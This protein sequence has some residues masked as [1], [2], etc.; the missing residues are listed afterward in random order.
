MIN[1]ILALNCP[2]TP[3]H[4]RDI[5][6]AVVTGAAVD[7]DGRIHAGALTVH[8]RPVEHPITAEVLAEVLGM[9][10]NIQVGFAVNNKSDEPS[11]E[12]AKAAMTVAAA[13]LAVLADSEATL[14]YEHDHV[15]MR[16]A[17]GELIL[18]DWWPQWSE[19][20]IRAQLPVP[21]IMT[22][23]SGQLD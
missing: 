17:A 18:F 1:F 13:R 8:V 15:F 23:E 11:Y 9:P 2:G 19:P 12:R 5:L 22:S 6:R 16:R 10:A 20:A 7:S 3:D 14:L 4:V 21:W